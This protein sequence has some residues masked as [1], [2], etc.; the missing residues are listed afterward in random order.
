MKV[1]QFSKE[2]FAK[3]PRYC[4]ISIALN[5]ALS[6]FAVCSLFSLGPIVDLYIHPDRL[7][8]LS[9][10]TQKVIHVMGFFHMPVNLKS[11]L[12]V[13][14]A[15]VT[16]SCVFQVL[17][18][19]S[20]LA[21]KYTVQ[22][23]IILGSF[24]DFFNARWPFFSSSEHGTLYNTFYRELNQLGNAFSAMGQA[25]A[26]IVQVVILLVVP[27]LISWQVT[28]LSLSAGLAFSSVFLLIGS[29]AYRLGKKNTEVSNRLTALIHESISGAKLVLGY[30]NQ[31]R[32]L[33]DTQEAYQAIV[34]PAIETQV[35]N[36]A[37]V[38]A[39]R[40]LGVVVVVVA[41]I[42]S[43]FFAVPISD[44]AVLFLALFQVMISLGN[45]M[46]QKNTI[47]NLIPSYEQIMRLRMKAQSMRQPTGERPFTG[48]H[49]DIQMRDIS[50]S[51]PGH[52]K[53]LDGIQVTIPKG[54]MIAFVGKSGAGK[55]T[56]ID[57]LMGF[58][59]PES[60]GIWVDGI[61][62]FDLDIATYRRRLGYVP[63]ESQLFDMSIRDNLRWVSPQASRQDIEN[64]CRQAYAHEFIEKMPQHYDT[65]V[66]NRGVRLSGGQIQRLALARAFLRNPDIL[67]LDEATSSLDSHSEQLIQRAIENFAQQSTVV[68]V[69][70]RLTT[71]KKADLIYVLHEGRVIEQGGYND[72]AEQNGMFAGMVQLQELGLN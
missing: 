36:Y 37:I 4:L 71:I 59:Q 26:G 29:W 27:F 70:H 1:F 40:P 69:A 10:L 18:W 17:G 31:K 46:G 33:A 52:P 51:H 23:D 45:V 57:M 5:V 24:E 41:I 16:V 62:L 42:A 22:K 63:Q 2:L 6:F 32:L 53:V 56:L 55:S 28:L 64:A 12:F 30:S 50:F 68:I 19:Q 38:I 39:Y 61:N 3:Y 72:L 67:I 58:Y 44:I 21:L 43:S 48:L 60:G 49:V 13:F 7:S 14:M 15:F 34:R 11:W 9:P 20:V 47:M 35:L 54:R 66:G 8:Q 25:F 65:V